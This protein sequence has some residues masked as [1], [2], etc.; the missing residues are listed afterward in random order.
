MTRVD[1]SPQWRDLLRAQAHPL[2]G[3]A[4]DYDALLRLIGDARLVLLGDA[5]HGSQEL[6]EERIRLTKRLIADCGFTGVAIDAGVLE[7][8]RINRYIHGTS[9]AETSYAA[10]N[11]FKEFPRWLWCNTAMPDFVGWLY[12]YNKLEPHPARQVSLYGLDPYSF[13]ASAAAL[14]R[15]LAQEDPAAADR[16]R[17]YFAQFEQF[18]QPLADAPALNLPPPLLTV[19]LTYLAALHTFRAGQAYQRYDGRLAEDEA[20]LAAI[21]NQASARLPDY[22]RLLLAGHTAAWNLREQAMQHTLMQLARHLLRR[23][24]HARIVVWGHNAHVGDLQATALGQQGERSLGELARARY[25]ADAVLIGFSTHH[26]TFTAADAWDAPALPHALPPA[27]PGSYEDLFHATQIPGFWL[28]LS[29]NPR[30]RLLDSLPHLERANG[31]I[32]APGASPEQ[33]Y[34]AS[35]L[36]QQFDAVIHLDETHAVQPLDIEG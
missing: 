26:G 13:F 2:A 19:L 8:W 32:L 35:Q 12:A 25:G 11:D 14:L 15:F 29:R 28:A 17:R 22:Y 23:T 31:A 16:A 34:M 5:T 20:F 24:P 21:E 6:Y 10:L 27:L 33:E 4:T 3:R 30:M 9:S 1:V 7:A 36:S 18:G